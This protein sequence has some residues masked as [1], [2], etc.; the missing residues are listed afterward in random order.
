M[1]GLIFLDPLSSAA[2]VSQLAAVQF[3]VDEF[4]ID[5]QAGRQPGNPGDQRLA[6]RFSGGNELQ[7]V[8]VGL[9][10][11]RQTK[12]STG[13]IRCGKGSPVRIQVSESRADVADD[14]AIC[15]TANR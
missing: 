15:H 7:H 13:R 1:L 14:C 6:V 10:F 2:P 9:A 5:G 8:S 4:Q 3:A 11:Q 12:D